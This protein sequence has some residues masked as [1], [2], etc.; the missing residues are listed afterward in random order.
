MEKTCSM[1]ISSL[2]DSEVSDS[3][4]VARARQDPQAF[5][6]LYDR[7]LPVVYRYL[8]AR[9]GDPAEVEDLTSQVFLDALRA[10]PRY[11]HN[12]HFAAWLLS[13]ARRKA[14]DHYRK[15]FSQVSIEQVGGVYS[16]EPNPLAQVV[17]K[18][19][20]YRLS[21]LVAELAEE[22]RELLRLRFAARLN[23]V[24]M[25][26]LL[27]R[28]ESAVKMALYRLLKRLQAQLE[29]EDAC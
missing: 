14:A 29:A 16:A 5:A 3:D 4:L 22:E 21:E 26:G 25:A 12:G 20:L 18:D 27:K 24:E 28:K 6:G 13:I 1:K 11:R 8:Y 15:H 23:F 9:I 19:E 10:F 17:Y 7:Y 2:Q